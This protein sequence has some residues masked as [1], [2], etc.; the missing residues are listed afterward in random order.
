MSD[1]GVDDRFDKAVK[2][3]INLLEGER[4]EMR[5]RSKGERR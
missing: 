1:I 4:P 3:S 2:F 5:Q